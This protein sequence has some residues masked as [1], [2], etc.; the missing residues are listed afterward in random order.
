ML[1]GEVVYL[2]V[3][4]DEYELPIFC[5]ESI[6]ELSKKYGIKSAEIETIIAEHTICRFLVHNRITECF[7]IKVELDDED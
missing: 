5:A 6:K 7:I 4:A 2:V 3:I 1:T